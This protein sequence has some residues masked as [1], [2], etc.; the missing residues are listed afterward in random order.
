MKFHFGKYLTDLG[1]FDS[2]TGHDALAMMPDT[3]MTTTHK[4]PSP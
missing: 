3:K 1:H 4:D 2:D